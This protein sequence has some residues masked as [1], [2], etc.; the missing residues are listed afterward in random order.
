MKVRTCFVSNSSSSSFIICVKRNEEDNWASVL[1]ACAKMIEYDLGCYDSDLITVEGFTL[2]KYLYD[3]IKEYEH[4]CRNGYTL[5]HIEVSSE[6]SAD[7]AAENILNALNRNG[8]DI[9]WKNEDY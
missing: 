8:Y 3:D 7:E 6:E 1:S 4:D 2:S 9:K 5:E